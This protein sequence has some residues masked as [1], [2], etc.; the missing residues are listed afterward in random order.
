MGQTADPDYI[1]HQ[2]PGPALTTAWLPLVGCRIKY[3][4]CPSLQSEV[5]GAFGG[6]PTESRVRA[7]LFPGS[8]ESG[9]ETFFSQVRIS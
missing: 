1:C 8:Q 2:S 6:Q 9:A 5:A 4:P 7:E 3:A